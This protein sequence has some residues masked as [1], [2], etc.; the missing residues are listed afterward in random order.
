MNALQDAQL[1]GF[2]AAKEIAFTLPNGTSRR[3]RVNG[4]VCNYTGAHIDN[5]FFVIGDSTDDL[6]NTDITISGKVAREVFEGFSV[7]MG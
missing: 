2:E 3:V 5:R 1:K 7:M 6:Q 4:E